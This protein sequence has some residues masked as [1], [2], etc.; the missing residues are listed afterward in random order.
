MQKERVSILTQTLLA[1]NYSFNIEFI[2]FSY[3]VL[4]LA[5]IKWQKMTLIAQID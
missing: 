4:T 3:Q 2:E 5:I 1:I